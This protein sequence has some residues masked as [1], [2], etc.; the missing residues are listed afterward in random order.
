LEL[1]ALDGLKRKN[2]NA[3]VEGTFHQRPFFL[4]GIITMTVER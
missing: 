1:I 4:S 2:L 3:S